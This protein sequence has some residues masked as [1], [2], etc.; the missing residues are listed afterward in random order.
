MKR[1]LFV[2]GLASLCATAACAFLGGVWLLVVAVAGSL[3]LLLAVV[4]R[5]PR[6]VLLAVFAGVACS[7]LGLGAYTLRLAGPVH[8]LQGEP[9]TL[10]GYVVSAL[11]QN[12]RWEYI[13]S[14]TLP[15]VAGRVN[16]RLTAQRDMELAVCQPVQGQGVLQPV[17]PRYLARNAARQIAG[18]LRLV[19]QFTTPQT[20]PPKGLAYYAAALRLRLVTALQR[21]VPYGGVI[22]SAMLLAE[23]EA[24]PEQLY[25]R[26]AAAG[27][28][29][30]LVVSGM[31]LSIVVQGL[32]LAG[33]WLRLPRRL[34][35]VLGAVAVGL[36]CLLAGFS[37]SITRA[38]VMTLLMLAGMALG[39]RED[40]LTSLGAAALLICLVSPYAVASPSFV[41]SFATTLSICLFFAPLQRGARRLLQR[42][43]SLAKSELVRGLVGCACLWLAAQLLGLPLCVL[44]F[45]YLPTYGLLAN[46]GLFF[47]LPVT[48]LSGAVTTL[49]G[50]AGL[51]WLAAGAGWLASLCTQSIYGLVLLLAR[52][53]LATIPVRSIGALAALF[54]L[55]L[56]LM[57]VWL[58]GMRR[59]VPLATCLCLTAIPFLSM[60]VA[61]QLLRTNTLR[62]T[63]C[64]ESGSLLLSRS[65]AVAVIDLP[66]QAGRAQKALDCAASLGNDL[67]LLCATYDIDSQAARIA[68]LE[69]SRPKL[70]VI[71]AAVAQQAGEYRL[72]NLPALTGEQQVRLLD[73]AT[74]T[75]RRGISLVEA[76]GLRIVK[77]SAGCDLTPSTLRLLAGA[78]LLVSPQGEWRAL[79]TLPPLGQDAWGD[80]YL[81]IEVQK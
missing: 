80:T 22:L 13:I 32:L 4:W 14:T 6:P 73:C 57:L 10:Q 11:P 29:H 66:E 36:L 12:G 30:V 71:P 56:V 62:I 7:L 60:G 41:L 39:R 81:E 53:P 48:L 21:H 54:A 23:R 63:L 46:L 24:I 47:L 2:A 49:L 44:Y 59:F 58:L 28:A 37:P 45:G 5:V 16:L 3:A 9:L 20:L 35:C 25:S 50:L 67:H 27:V 31:H 42:S 18:E 38:G 43:P 52:L 68:A 34:V 76:G 77:L 26:F 74:L 40:A 17:Q 64:A 72:Q 55:P 78:D 61:Q 69:N 51:S 33:A 75:T 65:G 8:R 15:G 1:P 19:G 70:A 79:G